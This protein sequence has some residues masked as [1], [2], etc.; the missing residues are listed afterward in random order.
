LSEAKEMVGAL[1]LLFTRSAYA[2]AVVVVLCVES[3]YLY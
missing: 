2:R 1:V 3:A